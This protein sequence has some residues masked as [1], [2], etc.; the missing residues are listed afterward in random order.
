[1]MMLHQILEL[2]NYPEFKELFE[3]TLNEYEN[4]DGHSYFFYKFK[5]KL[6]QFNEDSIEEYKNTKKAFDL[7]FLRELGKSPLKDKLNLPPGV[8][9]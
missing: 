4:Y 3:T 7:D 1:M 2:I 9:I 5:A 8:T 6:A